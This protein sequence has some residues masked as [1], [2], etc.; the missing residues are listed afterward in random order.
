MLL[1]TTPIKWC[2]GLSLPVY[3][4]GSADHELGIKGFAGI[5]IGDWRRDLATI[6]NG[7]QFADIREEE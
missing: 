3:I 4:D 2:V 1:I 6:E 5:E 7:D